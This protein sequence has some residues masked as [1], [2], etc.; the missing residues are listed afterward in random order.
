MKSIHGIIFY[1]FI[2]F[3]GKCMFVLNLMPIKYVYNVN[4]IIDKCVYFMFHL[5][6]ESIS[7]II[8]AD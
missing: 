8:N 1:I 5:N 3:I 7:T 6:V 4:I 2:L